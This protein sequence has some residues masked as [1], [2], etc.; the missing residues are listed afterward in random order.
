MA[1]LKK[2]K[3]DDNLLGEVAV[4]DAPK[5]DRFTAIEKKAAKPKKEKI[6]KKKAEPV[7]RLALNEICVKSEH[8]TSDYALYNADCIEAL[9][10]I[11]DNSI[12]YSIFSPPFEGMYTYSSSN[13]DFG[14]CKNTAEFRTHNAFLIQELFRVIKPGRNLSFHCM[15]LPTSKQR[16]GYIGIRDF[17]GDLIFDFQRAGFIYH[18]EVCIWKDPVTAMQRSKAL[19]LLYKQLKK[20]S[21]MSRQG[22]PDYLV[23]MRKP[24]VNPH[25][26]TKAGDRTKVLDDDFTIDDWQQYASPVWL[27]LTEN[28]DFKSMQE[29]VNYCYGAASPVWMDIDQG[30]TLQRVREDEDERHICP[31]QLGVIE[32][33]IRLWTNKGDVVLTPFLG[34]G[35]E[36]F[37]AVRMGRKAVGI[38]LKSI[39]YQQACKNLLLADTENR[40]TTLN[41]EG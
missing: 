38:E 1:R 11:P 40:Q 37:V 28:K 23:T 8:I 34:I 39:Y 7:R 26:V 9:K 30:N 2:T 5:E 14:N 6:V 31:L 20:D 15:N 35:S 19:G 32:R 3:V 22:I 33:G 12:D 21:A 36:A 25:P 18:S 16:D 13:R 17:R 27:E 24:G 29:M 10:G 41:F 4:V